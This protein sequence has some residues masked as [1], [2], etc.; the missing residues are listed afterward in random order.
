MPSVY[1]E[2]ALAV[3]CCRRRSAIGGWF[4]L[5]NHAISAATSSQTSMSWDSVVTRAGPSWIFWL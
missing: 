4:P 3:L 5:M 1:T 2:V